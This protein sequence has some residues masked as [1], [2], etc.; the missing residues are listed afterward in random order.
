M[1]SSVIDPFVTTRTTRK[2]GLG[3]PLVRQLA[4]DTD[5]NFDI[6]S[7]VG[8]GTVLSAEFKMSH[9]DRPPLGDISSTLVTI[10]SSAPDIR[11]IYKHATDNGEFVLDTDEVKTMLEG[12]PI[13]S[14]E[15]LI[16]LGEYLT[17]NL[18]SIEGGKI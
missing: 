10:I 1:L 8:E 17:E 15:I 13:D 4:L 5:G 14:P 3:I 11:Y 18:N 6:K 16:W 12:I 7:K 2:V 9:L